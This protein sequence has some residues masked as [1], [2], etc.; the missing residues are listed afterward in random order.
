MEKRGEGETP[1]VP[2]ASTAT[3]NPC[4]K[5]QRL[6]QSH[7]VGSG[8]VRRF[9]LPDNGGMPGE[10][11]TRCRLPVPR[12]AAQ[13]PS[14]FT[15]CAAIPV[16]A[17]WGLSGTRFGCY[18]SGSTLFVIGCWWHCKEA[19]ADCQTAHMRT[20]QPHPRPLSRKLKR[21]AKRR[22]R[23]PLSNFSGCTLPTSCRVPR[24]IGVPRSPRVE[25][26]GGAAHRLVGNA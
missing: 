8:R 26:P 21:G 13:L 16:S 3:K 2:P 5:A 10:D 24:W 9:P 6:R 19:Q 14:P 4:V 25:T 23:P 22:R 11:Y 18:S 17:Y 20:L 7:F 12:F 15:A 1:A